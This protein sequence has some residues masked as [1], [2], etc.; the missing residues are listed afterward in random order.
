MNIRL[1]LL[2]VFMLA[3]A[4]LAHAHGCSGGTD[5]GMDA[6]GVAC[7]DPLAAASPRAV[8]EPPA[9]KRGAAT[10]AHPAAAQ[11]RR[12]PVVSAARHPSRAREP[13]AN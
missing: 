4:P 9:G 6:T 3:A 1:G 11:A 13:R 2:A 7:N 10:T 5:G 12:M 8:A